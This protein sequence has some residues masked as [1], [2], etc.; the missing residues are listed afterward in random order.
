MTFRA[1]SQTGQAFG[2]A[3]RDYREESCLSSVA[4]ARL[5]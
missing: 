3:I 5:K 2:L 1:A 4:R